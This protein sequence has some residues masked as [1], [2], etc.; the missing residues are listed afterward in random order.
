MEDE[1]YFNEKHFLSWKKQK[2]V[3]KCLSSMEEEGFF[4]NHLFSSMEDDNKNKK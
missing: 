2:N 1:G 4:N 3:K